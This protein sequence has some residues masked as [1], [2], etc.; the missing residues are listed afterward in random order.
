VTPWA[1]G[2]LYLSWIAPGSATSY[3]VKRSVNGGTFASLATATTPTYTDTGLTNYGAVYC[4]TVSALVASVTS[5]DTPAVCNTPTAN[6]L[7]VPNYS[8][9]TPSV[10]LWTTGPSALGSAS[11]TF[12]GASG[13]TN[14]N[15]SGI[16]NK[17][18]TWT[19]SNLPVGPPA[20]VQVAFIEGTGS[21]TQTISG[22]TPGNMYT[23]TVAA[24]QRQ[25]TTQ[26]GP[27]PFKITVNGTS[28]GT[29]S[30]PQSIG[31]Y[32]DYSASFPATATSN[33]IAFV[34]TSSSGTSAVLLDNVRINTAGT[35]TLTIAAQS[36]SIIY[37]AASTVLTASATLS[38][39]TALGS[40]VFQVGSGSQIPGVCT[41]SGSTDICTV[42]Y[43]TAN[44]PLGNNTI[45]VT[46]AGDPNYA[47]ASASANLAVVAPVTVQ[48]VTQTALAAQ[49]DGS[50]L[51]TVTVSNTGSSTA[52]DVVLTGMSLG[53][54]SGAPI[55][56]MLGN[57][58][59]G[60]YASTTVSVPASAGA[61][62]K[63]IVGKVTGAYSDGTFGGSFRAALP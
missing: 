27:N 52:Q 22:F 58:A 38:N 12:V 51:A 39:G 45:T 25:T 31:Y 34:G 48:L 17:S 13:S 61:P 3:T 30:P 14:G 37:G 54:V 40:L 49:N 1:S 19:N 23:I 28:I 9:E 2:S 26:S 63:A 53:S 20:G 7:T 60:G 5:S 56:Q 29:F 44:L 8:F 24:S 62:G 57:I 10:P 42:T 47:A 32:E 43:P 35:G 6:F 50:Y 46:Y 36:T 41:V 15:N 33:T 59:P 21:V 55:P 18:G 11:W 16:S 4:Y